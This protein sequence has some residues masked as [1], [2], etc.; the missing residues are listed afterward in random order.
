MT[1]TSGQPTPNEAPKGT[2][3][4]DTKTPAGRLAAAIDANIPALLMGA[5]GTAKTATIEALA[6]ERGAHLEIVIASAQDP[7]TILG[8]PM[9]SEDRKHTLPTTPGWVQRINDAHAKGLPTILFLDELT[10]VA[11]SVAG[12]LL[13]VVQSRRADGWTLPDDTRIIAAANPPDLAVGGWA[14]E[15]AMANRWV[16]I[17]WPAPTAEW[18]A[19]AELQSSPTLRL[20]AEYIR[21]VPNE[22]LAVPTDIRKRSGAWPSPRSWT[23]AAR[24]VDATGDY[25]IAGLAVGDAA[26]VTF[27]TWA[28]KRDVPSVADLLAGT[29]ELP[30]RHDA[31]VTALQSLT[32]AVTQDT[33]PRTLD[34]L[35]AAVATDPSVV[36]IVTRRMGQRGFVVGIAGLVATIEAHGIDFGTVA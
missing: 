31:F 24:L 34:I 33:L 1:A 5:P 35:T 30:T 10:T 20:L 22:L 14:V 21:T 27:A 36:A 2:R 29:A 32:E 15:P 19:W 13:G 11:P 25:F 12:P 6:A 8:I 18:V 16:H 7:T 26:A 23:N 4:V 28:A 9:P 17:D 3:T